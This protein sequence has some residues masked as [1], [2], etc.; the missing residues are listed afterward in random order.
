M[1]QK[2][3]DVQEK[4]FGQA[5]KVLIKNS[6]IHPF[7]KCLWALQSLRIYEQGRYIYCLPF[8]SSRLAKLY[9]KT[10]K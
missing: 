5:L 10:K 1:N 6:I 2:L 3:E 4:V 9:I 8:K 7:D